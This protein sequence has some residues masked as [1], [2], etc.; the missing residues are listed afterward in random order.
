MKNLKTAGILSLFA[1]SANKNNVLIRRLKY[2]RMGKNP[3]AFFIYR[4]ESSNEVF[5]PKPFFQL[6]RIINRSFTMA[7]FAQVYGGFAVRIREAFVKTNR[8]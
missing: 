8:A 2:S 3:G 7:A 6:S 1:N 4:L 5:D